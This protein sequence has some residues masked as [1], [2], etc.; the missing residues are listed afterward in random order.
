MSSSVLTT[1]NS[2]GTVPPAI[3]RSQQTDTSTPPGPPPTSNTTNTNSAKYCP[4]LNWV[5][6]IYEE[7]TQYWTCTTTQQAT[8]NIGPSMIAT[9]WSL[10]GGGNTNG[11]ASAFWS[12]NAV[13]IP[14]L[15]SLSFSSILPDSSAATFTLDGS[16]ATNYIQYTYVYANNQVPAPLPLAGAGLAY[17]F[18][19]RL[20]RRIKS[21]STIVS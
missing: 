14:S 15:I 17:G 4:G 20:R 10:I 19:R 8:F 21:S 11:I 16:S 7:G 1:S 2:T 13:N 12:G 6:G 5:A 9:N 3:L 18:S